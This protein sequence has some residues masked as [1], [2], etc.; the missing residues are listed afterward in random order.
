MQ[1]S[2]RENF[3]TES[4]NIIIL[5]QSTV[6]V[7]LLD[8]SWF[9]L[10]DFCSLALAEL[11]ATLWKLVFSPNA[12]KLLC[13]QLRQCL[14]VCVCVC[15]VCIFKTL[16][17]AHQRRRCDGKW[18]SVSLQM[19]LEHEDTLWPWPEKNLLDFFCS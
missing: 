16:K 7:F 14:M 10:P 9:L 19:P 11:F 2:S 3:T 5:H 18:K 1:V 8:F 12:A 17:S 4:Q 15:M 6:T 13:S